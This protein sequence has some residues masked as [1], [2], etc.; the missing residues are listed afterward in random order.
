M[1]QK[2]S[3][4]ERYQLGG[5]TFAVDPAAKLGAGAEGTVY[6]HP[7]DPAQCVKLFHPPDPS[8]NKA[9]SL[10]DYRS[11]K[12]ANVCGLGL[13]L[14]PQFILPA[15]PAYDLSSQKVVGFQMPKLP[16][17]FHKLK[18]LLEGDFR[19]N[20]QIGLRLIAELFADIFDDLEVVHNSGLVVGDVNMGCLMF[21][22]NGGRAWV[23]T[24]S[25]SYPNFPCLAVTE[26]FAHPDLYGY[27]T[28]TGKRLPQE[29]RHDRF[30]FLLALCVTAIPGAHPFRMGT[31][32]TAQGIQHRTNTGL[33][34]FDD[35]VQWPAMVS[36]PEVLSDEL[37]DE[38]VKRLKRQD[39]S[40]LPHDLLRA[41][42]HD[43]TEC[44]QC[45]TQYH[46]SRR[47]CPQCQQVTTV[48]VTGLVRLLVEE[49]FQAPGVL[50]FAQVVGD[51]L[52]LVCRVGN[53]IQVTDLASD[54]TATPL[55]PHLPSIPGARYR[56]FADCLVVASSPNQVAPIELELYRISG[57]SLTRLAATSTGVLEGEG[58]VFDASPRFL[59]RTAG[60]ALLRSD[61]F[62]PR[63]PLTDTQVAEVYQGQSWFT[64][65]HSS[66][67]DHEVIF[68]YDRALRDWQWFVIL[69]NEKGSR[70]Q[71]H[72][73]QDLSLRTNETVEDFAV[74][75]SPKSVLLVMQ[76]SYRG[77]DYVR[78]AVIG[79]D[80]VVHL[81][82]IVKSS[83]DTYPYWE[84]LR[85]KL[86][87]GS[88]VLHV[89]AAGVVKQ[90]LKTRE[91]T[92]YAETA[93]LVS[94][95]DRLVR[96]HGQIGIFRRSGV[97]TLSK[98]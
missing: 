20:H 7:R 31:H 80:G 68:G 58:A 34:I 17:D 32:P 8:D 91:C 72:K 18:R 14:P 25:W 79:H 70:Y 22:S 64:V 12:V 24:D 73:V 35:E 27:L 16:P 65:D 5:S 42:A 97:S 48:Q 36:A 30:A 93:G 90:D 85:G 9:V 74:H 57:D 86:H 53:T 52:Y 21:Q 2:K 77:R 3:A 54:G 39:E 47:R 59:Y 6:T 43:V 55:L 49:L 40:P 94:T 98:K 75:F 41:F 62:G 84:N 87:Q 69:G 19:R 51:H 13:T 81:N 38:L 44:A 83:D 78:Y 63:G 92:T 23:D 50:L 60:N 89:T 82:E 45:G 61:L 67:A 4:L 71:Y 66:G 46:A 33:T 29:P 11:R 76:T 15:V 88:S 26:M 96:F 1:P 95:D 56:F 10:A 37:L 28:P